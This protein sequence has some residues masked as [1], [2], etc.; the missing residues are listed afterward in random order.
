MTRDPQPPESIPSYVVDPLRRQDLDSLR[1]I[2][3]Y[4]EELIKTREKTP[5]LEKEIDEDEK[6]MKKEEE[7]GYTRVIKK[8]PCGKN[9]S[10]CPHGPYEYHV[11]WNGKSL[12]W[13]YKGK[14]EKM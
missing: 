14:V 4:L 12:D 6:I 8:V 2:H 5:D 13:E 3:T 11:T 1:E 10:G 7:S 9:C